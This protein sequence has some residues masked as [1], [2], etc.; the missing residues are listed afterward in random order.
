M[1][2]S[3][4]VQKLEVRITSMPEFFTLNVWPNIVHSYW[5]LY[6]ACVSRIIWC[7]GTI[8]SRCSRPI[9]SNSS[10]ETYSC[11][12]QADLNKI[13]GDR[14]T[15]NPTV[16]VLVSYQHNYLAFF[17]FCNH[18]SSGSLLLLNCLFPPWGEN[19]FFLLNLF[20]QQLGWAEYLVTF[21][22]NWKTNADFYA[23]YF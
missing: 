11:W 10:R 12:K 7:V 21:C 3:P 2:L 23:A 13:L 15:E 1:R 14:S 8:Y 4:C 5:L 18:P 17:F 19:T 6:F 9:L 22:L 20:I 16:C